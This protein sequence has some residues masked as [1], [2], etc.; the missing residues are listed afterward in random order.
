VK[1]LL[2]R[3]ANQAVPGAVPRVRA[4]ASIRRGPP[5]I[6]QSAADRGGEG[7]SV[8]RSPEQA[9]FR[10]ALN[11]YR[12]RTD[13]PTQTPGV[14][15]IESSGD[16]PSTR[17]PETGRRA[18]R[19]ESEHLKVGRLLPEAAAAIDSPRPSPFLAA[20]GDKSQDFHARRLATDG[21]IRDA[22]PS[23]VH[24]HIGRIEVTAVHEAAPRRSKREPTRPT[25]TLEEYLAPHPRRVP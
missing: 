18:E 1:G 22:E 17:A 14:S 6:V 16:G 12:A 10:E 15:P 25:K 19:S 4:A 24:V 13:V 9:S 23:E 8:A 7:F 20:R 21:P 11:E 3:L 2:Q 5:L